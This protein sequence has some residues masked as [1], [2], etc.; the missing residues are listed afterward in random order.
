MCTICGGSNYNSWITKSVSSKGMDRGRDYSNIY[1]QGVGGPW[2]QQSRAIPTTELKNP[3]EDQPFGT[4]YKVV[5]NGTIANDK[6]LG[7][8]GTHVDSWVL[9][10]L[11]FDST[12]TLRDSLTKVDGS[13]A[14]AVLKP[15]G[16]FYLA[17]NYEPL[18]IRFLDNKEFVFSSRKEFLTGPDDCDCQYPFLE[19]Y[20]GIVKIPPYTIL[21]TES[22]CMTPIPRHQSDKAVVIASAGLDST[23]VAAYACHKHGANNVTL[24][25]FNYGCKAED[26]ETRQIKKIAKRLGCS[27]QILPLDMS[28]AK[29]ASTLLQESSTI[30]EGVMGSEKCYEW[31]PARNFIMMAITVGYC[32]ANDFGHIYLG[33]NLEESGAYP[34][35]APHWI[36]EVSDVLYA[37]T[38][39]VKIGIHCPLEG[40]MKHDIVKFG[41]KYNAPF[42]LTISCYQPDKNG[43]ACGHCGPCYMRQIAFLRNGLKDPIEYKVRIEDN[44]SYKDHIKNIGL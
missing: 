13:Y 2:I 23:A 39:Q 20:A 36:K 18:Y 15:N 44:E 34:D 31:V 43:V 16:S 22:W 29:N 30:V 6:E 12:Y 26:A 42:D 21:D 4:V 9:Q 11:N 1:I 25:H 28:F 14:I 33:T 19:E 10:F 27:V 35:N 5:H 7:N 8:D 37:A 38:N 32:E 40:C 24:I 41:L 3:P 17:C